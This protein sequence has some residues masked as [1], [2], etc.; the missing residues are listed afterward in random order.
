MNFFSNL[1]RN[2]KTKKRKYEGASK[3]SRT[4][5][6][7]TGSGDANASISSGLITLRER[8]RDLR[9]NNPHAKK[10]IELI[11]NNVV[12]KGIIT[13]FDNEPIDDLWKDWASSQHCDYDGM[14][15]LMGLQR[16][17]M[18]AVVESG[19]VLIR[20]RIVI[21]LTIPLQ[22]QVLEADFLDSSLLNT[23]S[24]QK[25]NRIVQ[26]V[27]FD[28]NGKRVGYHIH[29]THPGSIDISI[30]GLQSNFVPASEIIHLYRIDRP[31]QVRGVPWSAPVMMRLKDLDDFEDAQLMRQKV[32]ACFTAFVHDISADVECDDTSE[33]LAEKIEPALIE[34]LPPGKTITFADPPSVQNYKEFTSSQLRGIASGYGTTYEGLTG[35][36]SETN[37]SSAR[38][39]WI[40]SGR[41]YDAWREHIIIARMLNIIVS[42]FK[43]V[44]SI[45]RGIDAL[46]VK[47]T[48]I[49]PRREMIDPTKEIPAM[50]ESIRGGLESRSSV[51][52]SM[53]RD[54]NE[55]IEKIAK[56]NEKADAL[57]LLLDSDPRFLTKNGKLQDTSSENGEENNEENQDT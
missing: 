49:P 53:G 14:N 7:T 4:S 56:D 43:E 17:A 54:S 35:D 6:W 15:N 11:T 37:F 48:H 20:K 42:D 26:G 19:E 8:S 2:K 41:N 27:E 36:L 47:A 25:N 30:S 44:L 39:G 13:Q 31:G 32:A 46:S 5:G 1:F 51:I 50:I 45:S 24:S 38:M 40:E 21:G 10:A 57:G 12:G 16:L 18:D 55:V 29:E 33:D 52:T 3:S 9:R 28:S 34:H 23:N 22:Y